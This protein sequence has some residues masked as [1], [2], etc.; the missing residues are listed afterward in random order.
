MIC[1]R[2]ASDKDL[3][4]IA[5]LARETWPS[6]YGKI[7]SPAQIDYML[8]KMYNA[9]ELLHQLSQGQTFI[10]AE[11]D[12]H[13]V[14]FAGFSVLDS[15][16]ALYKLH[17]LYVLPGQQGKGTGRLLLAE[18]ID[19][20]QRAKGKKLQLNVNRHNKALYF[21][22][23]QGFVMV[24]SVDLAIGNGYFMNDYVMEKSL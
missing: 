16:M 1:F 8:A 3:S 15:A 12:G 2:K 20:V 22:Q 11:E 5:K 21:Y 19:N 17:K 13:D 4:V 6:A 23:K 9:G 10:I 7:L 14:G 18:V 24:D